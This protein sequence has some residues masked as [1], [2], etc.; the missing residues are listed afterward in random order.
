MTIKGAGTNPVSK[1]YEPE[2]VYAEPEPQPQ[3]VLVDGSTDPA[4]AVCAEPV[5]T[6][7]PGAS[8]TEPQSQGKHAGMMKL[9]CFSLTLPNGRLTRAF[10]FNHCLCLLRSP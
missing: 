3:Q 4:I 9:L 1:T 8:S 10:F 2:L 5:P 6:A 7:P